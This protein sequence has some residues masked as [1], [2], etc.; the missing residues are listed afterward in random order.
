MHAT[1]A[2]LNTNTSN[3]TQHIH[4]PH[5]ETHSIHD[6]LYEILRIILACSGFILNA[7][8]IILLHRTRQ[9]LRPHMRLT[10]CLNITDLL[11]SLEV[12]LF[13]SI[14][15]GPSELIHCIKFLF[16]S[17]ETLNVLVVMLILL[18][19]AADQCIATVKPI[20]YPQIVTVRRTNIALASVWC[21]GFI[22]VSLGTVLSTENRDSLHEIHVYSCFQIQRQYTFFI[23][24]SLCVLTFPVF[25]TVYIVIYI[26]IRKLRSRD[27]L[28]GRQ[29][30]IKKATITTIILIFP[31]IMIYVPCAIY[32]LVAGIFEF[33]VDW[34]FWSI[35]M[36]LVAL[37][38]N[39]DPIICALRFKELKNG[40]I[41]MFCI[42]K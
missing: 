12:I 36:V 37:H 41:A 1:I 10:L 5:E 33:T 22:I 3:W 21:L 18:L 35:F 24:A 26:N 19:I 28:R 34:P 38:T 15:S 39:S 25:M 27:S 17:F 30:S 6:Q 31:F 8:T 42:C 13:F 11:L 4:K 16:Q 32:I 2:N 7:L 9:P 14:K 40:Y 23:N 20:H 29:M